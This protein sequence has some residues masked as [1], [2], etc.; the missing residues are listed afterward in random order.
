MPTP[1]VLEQQRAFRLLFSQEEVHMESSDVLSVKE[2]G[3]KY[4]VSRSRVY[5]MLKTGELTAVKIGKSTR[6]PRQVAEEWFAK[7]PSYKPAA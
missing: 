1:Y 3:R 4:A 7:R 2:F 6:I 5:E